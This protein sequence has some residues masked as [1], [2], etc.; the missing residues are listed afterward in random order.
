M[1]NAMFSEFDL[2]TK[3][4]VYAQGS[5]PDF[6]I[7]VYSM[8]QTSSY[9]KFNHFPWPYPLW[10][11]KMDRC[12][13]ILTL[14]SCITSS[15]FSSLLFFEILLSILSNACSK[16]SQTGEYTLKHLLFTWP[17]KLLIY[18]QD[19]IFAIC[20]LL[21]TGIFQGCVWGRKVPMEKWPVFS[22]KVDEISQFPIWSIPNFQYFFLF[23]LRLP[24]AFKDDYL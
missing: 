15:T 23:N 18:S 10:H 5:W 8:V 21:F 7:F 17:Y 16:K 12:L 1:Q 4:S 3:F 13:V 14:T 24:L 20:H 9:W 6:G 22:Q 2:S 11:R 19:F